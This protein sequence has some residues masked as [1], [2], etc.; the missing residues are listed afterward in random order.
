MTHQFDNGDVRRKKAI[1]TQ[2]PMWH[3]ILEHRSDLL[4]DIP[5]R[6]MHRAVGYQMVESKFDNES[7]LHFKG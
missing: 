6:C 4:F 1:C 3:K 5:Q 7:K 2:N